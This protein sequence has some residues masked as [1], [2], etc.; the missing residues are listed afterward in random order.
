VAAITRTH[1]NRSF[2]SWNDPDGTFC[3]KG[4]DTAD[5]G[6]QIL[7]HINSVANGLRRQRR[8]KTEDANRE[9]GDGGGHEPERALRADAFFAL[10][11]RSGPGT[12]TGRRS[13]SGSKSSKTGSKTGPTTRGAHPAPSGTTFDPDVDPNT[14]DLDLDALDP[15][16]DDPSDSPPDSFSLIDRPPTCSVMVRVDLAALLRGETHPGEICELDG[17]GPISPKM[18]RDMANDSFLRFIFHESEDI[19]SI[20]HFGRTI[21]KALRTALVHRDRSCVVPGCEVSY[22][23]EIDHIVPVTEGGPTTL[24]NLALLCHHH[25]FLKTFEGWTLEL[26]DVS[27][28]KHPRWRFEPLPPFGHE[29]D[30]GAD[31]HL[32]HQ[33][34]RRPHGRGDPEPDRRQSPAG[35][36]AGLLFEP[37]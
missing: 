3:Y 35:G 6:A 10:V 20:F 15:V 18:A 16:D 24:D 11:T 19:Q 1:A 32:T 8:A 27:D 33:K 9:A 23:L 7:N 22:G 29:P 13:A 37:G 21:N 28:P 17:H 30:L 5:R 14:L 36:D 2:A 12:G 25:H 26:M 34:W 4:T 31:G